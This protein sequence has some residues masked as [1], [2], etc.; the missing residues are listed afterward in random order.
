MKN[1]N[2]DIINHITGTATLTCPSTAELL[3]TQCL[4]WDLSGDATSYSLVQYWWYLSQAIAAMKLMEASTEIIPWKPWRAHPSWP[5]GQYLEERVG[6]GKQ[7]SVCAQFQCTRT[8][9]GSVVFKVFNS[10]MW[11]LKTSNRLLLLFFIF[12]TRSRG[13]DF[14]IRKQ[15]KKKFSWPSQSHEQLAKTGMKLTKDPLLWVA[16]KKLKQTKKKRC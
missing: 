10:A 8:F 16:L 2:C 11:S 4:W 3:V 12:F 1:N 15:T 14:Q 9:H 6:R 13:A 7:Q 5:K